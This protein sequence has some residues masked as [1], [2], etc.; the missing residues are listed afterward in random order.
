[1][2]RSAVASLAC[3]SPTFSIAWLKVSTAEISPRRSEFNR[4]TQWSTEAVVIG[5]TSGRANC[6]IRSE[7]LPASPTRRQQPASR[8]SFVEKDFGSGLRLALIPP[9]RKEA[10]NGHS[11]MDS[12]RPCG[13]DRRE[14]H[15]AGTGSGR[16]HHD[17]HSRNRRCAHRRIHRAGA[18]P[19]WTGRA[20]RIRRRHA[21][22]DSRSL[23]LPHRRTAPQHRLIG[24]ARRGVD[25]STKGR[26]CG[27]PFS[28]FSL[29]R[30][31]LVV[32]SPHEGRKEARPQLFLLR[33]PS[34]RRTS[35]GKAACA[36]PGLARRANDGS[37][38]RAETRGREK[39]E[40]AL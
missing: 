38:P 36:L 10:S 3:P 13:R 21:R 26:L 5:F 27:G 22:R 37:A 9:E 7:R 40:V 12:F 20:G 25:E 24:I 4:S 18:P 19:L 30:G 16:N 6:N 28:F 1:M 11:G 2:A 35:D 33:T 14:A 8:I 29:T 15:H 31:H 17:H 23:G 34:E 39:E 32:I